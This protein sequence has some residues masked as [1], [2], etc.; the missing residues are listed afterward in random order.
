[1]HRPLQPDQ[2]A[3]VIDLRPLILPSQKPYVEALLNK[4][5]QKKVP[6]FGSV[7]ALNSGFVIDQI[8]EECNARTDFFEVLMRGTV[9]SVIGLVAINVNYPLPDAAHIQLILLDAKLRGRGLGSQVLAA[10]E[11]R[12]R[13]SEN[14]NRI[15]LQVTPATSDLVNFW[16]KRG[17][18]QLGQMIEIAHPQTMQLISGVTLAKIF[19]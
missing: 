19:Q 7:P 2:P 6:L 1:M 16:R 10:L 5:T 9:Q 8:V 4:L 11:N 12:L 17:Y 13:Y 3:Q 14:V 18:L 15:S